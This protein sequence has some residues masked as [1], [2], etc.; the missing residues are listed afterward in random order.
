MYFIW[1][2]NTIL[3]NIDITK[4]LIDVFVLFMYKIVITMWNKFNEYNNI[5][6]YQ[7]ILTLYLKYLYT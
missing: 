2:L 3:Y 4:Y 6:N 1:F 5:Y 7:K